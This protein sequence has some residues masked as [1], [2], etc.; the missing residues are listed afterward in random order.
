MQLDSA[1]SQNYISASFS[2]NN[3]PYSVGG[4]NM[5][6]VNFNRSNIFDDLNLSYGGFGYLGGNTHTDYENSRRVIN[7]DFYRQTF[8]G[9]G[10]RTSVG[11]AEQSDNVEFRILNWESG[12]VYEAGSYA[13]FRDN[14]RAKN[15]TLS[16][17]ANKNNLFTTGLSTEIIF[18]GG[19][20]REREFG[21][22]IFLGKTLG[23]KEN[24]NYTNAKIS[25]LATDFSI[26][27]KVKKVFATIGGGTNLQNSSAKITMGYAF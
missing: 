25:G 14:I 12:F 23:L 2:S 10:F 1:K 6:F 15:D 16:V 26:F 8:Y 19:N 9:F 24:V 11:I 18:S 17:S 7:Q 21:F 3:I 20:K 5:G 27:T 22:R 4:M 13:S